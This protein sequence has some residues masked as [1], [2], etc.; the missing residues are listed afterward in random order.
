MSTTIRL[1]RSRDRADDAADDR[2]IAKSMFGAQKP[3]R[4]L[5]DLDAVIGVATAA[6]FLG[7]ATARIAIFGAL[8]FSRYLVNHLG[9]ADPTG[10]PPS[11]LMGWDAV[12]Y[13]RI[14]KSGYSH[15]PWESMRFFPLLAV[16][17]RALRPL[18]GARMAVLIPVN[19]AA[20]ASGFLLARLARREK[21]DDA[22]AARAGWLF[23][24]LPPAFVFAMGY[25]EALFVLCAIATFLALRSQRFGWAVVG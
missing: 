13:L 8:A 16:I 25:A 6:P 24:L 15:L 21:G 7:W 20:L 5:P 14:V 4:R 2:R 10:R 18:F 19:L 9:A 23:A 12:W 3:R 11:G 1:P 22:V 17:G